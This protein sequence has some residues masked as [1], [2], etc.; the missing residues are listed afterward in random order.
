[1]EAY[2]QQED[3]IL[4]LRLHKGD[5]QAFKELYLRYAEQLI[6]FASSKVYSLD[7]ARDIIHDLFVHLWDKRQTLEIKENLRSFLFTAVRYR[8]ID[9]IRKNYSR[10]EYASSMQNLT[11][12]IKMSL[13]KQIEDRDLI[14]NLNLAVE[15]LPPRTKE[16]YKLSREENLSTAEIAKLLSLSEQTVKNQISTALKYLRE[17]LARLTLLVPFLFFLR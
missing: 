4:I 13:Q 3:T 14:K 6:S 12:D 16:V 15:N 8:V 5:E 7:V 17:N 11:V 10:A 9:H 2:S 1:M